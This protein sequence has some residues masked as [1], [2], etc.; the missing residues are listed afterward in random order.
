MKSTSQDTMKENLSV[1][2]E[3]ITR[4]PVCDNHKATPWCIG[5]DRIYNRNEENKFVYSR[6]R[7]CKAVFESVRPLEN[8]IHKAY[9][10]E[11]APYQ[12]QVK[13]NKKPNWL[14]KSTLKLATHLVGQSAFQK[15]IK[16]LYSDLGSQHTFLDY[17]CGAGKFLNG[18]SK[19]ECRTIGVDFSSDAIDLVHKNGHEGYLVDQDIMNHLENSSIDFIRLNHVVEHL[20]Q[21][22][23][24][25]GDLLSKLKPGGRIHIAVP[26]PAGMTAQMFRS[27]WYGLECPRH[28]ILYPPETLELLLTDLG[29]ERVQIY[30]EPQSKDHIRSWGYMAEKLGLLAN[31]KVEGLIFSGTL[32]LIFA[33]PCRL[34]SFFNRA[35]RFHIEA[36]KPS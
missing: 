17:G 20:Y 5:V 7:N 27:L 30:N 19:R 31:D 33:I 36:R 22:H 13:N 8:E 21:P 1:R 24:V 34:A 28:I 23:E 12:A 18:M 16:N 25:L 29:F 3:K 26:N 14:R 35:D 15:S 4:C 10:I 32:Q 9:P 6:C 2:T 11:Y